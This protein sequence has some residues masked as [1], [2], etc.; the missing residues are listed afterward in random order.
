[1]VQGPMQHPDTERL[2]IGMGNKMERKDRRQMGRERAEGN[3]VT[4]VNIRGS[5]SV[6]CSQRVRT[7]STKTVV[8]SL[9]RIHQGDVFVL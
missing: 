9:T 5:G 4:L 7:R 3:E 1:M 8:Q 6:T 2:H